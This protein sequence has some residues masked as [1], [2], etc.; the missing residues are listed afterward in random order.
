MRVLVV[1]YSLEGNTRFIAESIAEAVGADLLEL[2]PKKELSS[3]GFMKYMW[4]GRQV[5]MGEKPE[6]M[7]FDKNPQDYDLIFIGSPVWAFSF[8]P[9][10]NTFL[11]NHGLKG[12]KVALFSSCGGTKG[13]T[14]DR[15]RKLLSGNTIA[16]EMEFI[17]PAKNRPGKQAE[18]ARDWA[19]SMQGPA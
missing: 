8:A 7:P 10:L 18:T 13:G 4:G 19:K 1:Y 16:G 3:K 6:L 2:K 9:P 5:V 14:F 11:S 17:E 15:M 12:R